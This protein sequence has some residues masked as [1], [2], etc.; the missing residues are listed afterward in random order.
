MLLFLFIVP[1]FD[2][3]RYVDLFLNAVHE[4]HRA[5]NKSKFV[6][7]FVFALTT[8]SSKRHSFTR[9]FTRMTTSNVTN[10]KRRLVTP[11]P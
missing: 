10:N 1:V 6:F 2:R 7:V 8:G 4:V 9:S 5:A 3:G 11:F